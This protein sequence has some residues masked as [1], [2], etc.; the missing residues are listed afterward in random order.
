MGCTRVIHSLLRHYLWYSSLKIQIHGAK[1]PILVLKCKIFRMDWHFHTHTVGL[2]NCHWMNITTWAG[3]K[4]EV[5]FPG[6]SSSE[7]Q[8][9]F[10][11]LDMLLESTHPSSVYVCASVSV[12]LSVMWYWTMS[13]N[14]FFLTVDLLQYEW[15]IICPLFVSFNIWDILENWRRLNSIK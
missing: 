2:L 7:K 12:S 11:K 6:D 9:V 13:S 8:E 10:I 3:Q 15:H 4:A 1:T 5:C 14:L